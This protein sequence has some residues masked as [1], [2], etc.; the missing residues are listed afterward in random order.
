MVE[1]D[2]PKAYIRRFILQN[3]HIYTRHI[4]EQ[5]LREAGYS[6]A[7]IEAAYDSLRYP[8]H[9]A[10]VD[11]GSRSVSTEPNLIGCLVFFP[12]VPVLIFLLA[13]MG[14]G[15]EG[16]AYIG[17]IIAGFVVPSMVKHNNPGL[18]KGMIYGFRTFL[19]L[20]VILPIVALLVL[21][22]ICIMS[23]NGN[24]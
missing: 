1:N 20:F 4:I 16:I 11:T 12:G 7:D 24:L 9:P 19:V 6:I 5:K 8:T 2:N 18:A 3:S 21:W 17:A 22:G 13:S 23:Y 14:S 10:P 15:L